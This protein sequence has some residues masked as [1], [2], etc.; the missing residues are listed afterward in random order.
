[1]ND[2]DNQSARIYVGNL[3][4]QVDQV[5]LRDRFKGYG[6]IHGVVILKGFGFVQF[7]MEECARAAIAGEAGTEFF[8]MQLDVKE[9]RRNK[10]LG[11]DVPPVDGA[12]NARSRRNVRWNI[13]VV[14]QIMPPKN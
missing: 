5:E 4:P 7:A 6:V 13:F 11:A 2:V 9:A 10:K 3:A 12:K 14:V 1:M 8:G